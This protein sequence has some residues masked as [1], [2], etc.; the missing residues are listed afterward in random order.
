MKCSSV[1]AKS[2][3]AHGTFNEPF[4]SKDDKSKSIVYSFASGR[5]YHVRRRLEIN[6]KM[7]YWANLTCSVHFPLGHNALKQ[8]RHRRPVVCKLCRRIETD[9]IHCRAFRSPMDSSRCVGQRAS[10]RPR[11]GTVYRYFHKPD[12][13]PTKMAR[14]QTTDVRERS[15]DQLNQI[16]S[17]SLKAV[18][19][20]LQIVVE[21][22]QRRRRP[23]SKTMVHTLCEENKDNL[24]EDDVH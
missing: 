11:T 3:R 9:A 17:S 4:R 16:F 8:H 5:G 20:H 23:T 7:T 10:N 21:Q 12:E 19:G 18:S 1:R 24:E 2:L 13:C 6:E 14:R 15:G 22:R